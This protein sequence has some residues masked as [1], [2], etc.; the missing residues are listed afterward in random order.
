[1]PMRIICVFYLTVC[2]S[3]SIQWPGLSEESTHRF[4]G[5]S[6]IDTIGDDGPITIPVVVLGNSLIFLL[7]SCVPD[8]QLDPQPID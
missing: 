6:R 4:E 2:V 7:T 5:V 1:M 3:S 8:L